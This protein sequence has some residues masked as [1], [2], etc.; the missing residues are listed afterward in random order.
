MA[1]H[2]LTM[3]VFGTES[4]PGQPTNFGKYFESNC[5]CHAH[6]VTQPGSS[7]SAGD[8]AQHDLPIGCCERGLRQVWLQF[9]E[10]KF[11]IQE[12]LVPKVLVDPWHPHKTGQV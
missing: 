5:V 4:R 12:N 1:W 11:E 8:S 2:S 10:F 9:K 6:L 7:D 3:Q